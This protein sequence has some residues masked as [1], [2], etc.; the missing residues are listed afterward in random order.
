MSMNEIYDYHEAGFRVFALHGIDSNGQCGCGD[1]E[2]NVN[3]EKSAVGKHPRASNGW[4]HTPLWGSEQLDVMVEYTVTT[5]FGVCIDDQVVIDI[6]PRN[7]GNGA[8][9]KL[10]ADTG[11]DFEAVSGFVVATGGGGRHIYFNRPHGVSLRQHL[12]GYDGLDF[13]SSGFVVGA[14]SIH[15][16]GAVYEVDKGNPDDLTDAPDALIE[17]LRKPEH[18]R[19]VFDGVQVDVSHAELQD[20]L[21]YISPDC[22]YDTWIQTGMS[23]HDA[24]NGEG[25]DIFDR[26]SD[27]SDKYPGRHA[28]DRHWSSFGRS[29][30]PVTIATLVYHAEQAGYQRPV[31]FPQPPEESEEYD[32][33]LDKKHP[34]SVQ[35]VDTTRPPGFVGEVAQWINAQCRFPREH[36]ASISALVSIGNVAGLRYIDQKDGTTANLFAFCVAGS[37]TGKEAVMQS[38]SAIHRAAGVAA[39]EVGKIKSDK[40]IYENLIRHQAAYYVIDELGYMLQKV[41]SGGK[42]GGAAYMDGVIASLMSIY[43]KASTFQNL[44]GDMKEYVRD[45]LRKERAQCKKAI[46]ENEDA[47]GF[48]A[49]RLPQLER[50]LKMINSGLERPFLSMIGFTTPVT[51]DGLVTG[52]QATNGF[53]GRSILI[54]EA[55]TNPRRKKGFKAKP[56]PEKMRAT[57]QNLYS[58]GEYSIDERGRIENY[59]D[60]IE[61][62]TDPRASEMLE[63]VADW[64]E[65]YAE[66]NK[67]SSGLEA[68]VRRAYELVSKVSLILAIPEG[69]RT[70]EH[71]RWAYALVRQDVDQKIALAQANQMEHLKDGESQFQVLA[72][73]IKGML[74]RED[75]ETIAVIKSRL[76]KFKKEDVQKALEAL[77]EDGE[78][79]SV[80]SSHPKNGASVTKWFLC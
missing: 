69:L 1:P 34:F 77:E 28:I 18:K 26:W 75:G 47:D 43:S 70:P 29:S 65:D 16:S 27:Q 52:E 60:P 46:D 67:A 24:T 54:R 62:P 33:R 4:Q 13:K 7:G 73:R 61:V 37:A 63:D 35:G 57:L 44:G 66:E 74:G 3:N 79:C 11:I 8:Y 78:V 72:N 25:M 17:L 80:E 71:V 10:C 39:A 19:A 59:N 51:F 2:C 5:G 9:K 58:P 32:E 48:C 6:D 56:M 22:D 38:I 49:K 53:I 40:E 14:G 30:N 41:A 76:K 20:M 36:L 15:K 64:C 31:T 42:A 23:L 55:Q 45:S 12:P 50:A 21:S 68:V